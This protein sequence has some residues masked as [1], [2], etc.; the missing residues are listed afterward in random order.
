MTIAVVAPNLDIL[1]GQSVQARSLMDALERN[2]WR[3]LFVPIN[4]R[5]P[6]SL[7]WARRVPVVRTLL[8]ECLYLAGLTRLRQADA[9]HVFSASY[10]SFLL[11]PVPAIVAAR[12]FAKPVILNYH[13]GEAQDHLARYGVL[14]HPWLR[15][16]DDIVVPSAYLQEIFARHG[17]ATRVVRNIIDT[18]G[19]R[20]RERL[21]LRPV[22]L[23]N[24]NLEAH[25]R[26]DVTLDAFARLRRRWPEARLKIAGYGR[27]R[28][29]LQQRAEAAGLEG[30]EFLGRVEP[31]VM[32]ALYE[33]ADIFVNASVVDNQPVSILEAFAAG[34]PVVT[35]PTGDIPALVRD[36]ETG[37]LVPPDDPEALAA[38]IAA[39]LESPQQAARMARIARR[40]V[41]RFTWGEVCAAW[42]DLYRMR[43]EIGTVARNES[44]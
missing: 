1:G 2:G 41:Q 27:E 23:S 21:P 14:V 7:R 15:R 22:L 11:A 31:D 13:S 26:V 25:Y 3:V 24:R 6:R 39:L 17:Y 40:A 32:P 16:V 19:F 34:L 9:V 35:T 12:L 37:T 43:V 38:A 30:V 18:S 42:T 28:A 10:W 20:Y 4:P 5:F 8:N 44:C 36:G 29:R 33:E